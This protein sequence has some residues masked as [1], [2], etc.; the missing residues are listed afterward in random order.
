M[1]PFLMTLCLHVFPLR[2]Y[3]YGFIELKARETSESEVFFTSAIVRFEMCP[4]NG[5]LNV[6]CSQEFAAVK[7]RFGPPSTGELVGSYKA[8]RPKDACDNILSGESQD[9]ST[10]VPVFAL[11]SRGNCSFDTKVANVEKAGFNAAI[12]YAQ[13]ND[14][15]LIE[16]KSSTPAVPVSIP[17]FYVSHNTGVVLMY[18]ALLSNSTKST[19]LSISI[20]EPSASK[21]TPDLQ[22]TAMDDGR[23][24]R[25]GD[26]TGDNDVEGDSNFGERYFHICIY[27]W[28]CVV[29]SSLIALSIVSVLDFGFLWMELF[30]CN[31]L[32]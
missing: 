28:A 6:T 5:L 21:G 25:S 19:L 31:I 15:N 1:Y 14:T 2:S 32:F 16:M 27:I 13:K 12:I 7:A 10:S 4:P 22:G 11:I 20:Q 26:E 30:S 17:A 8:V 3:T 29:V 9:L 23:N 24:G 18:T